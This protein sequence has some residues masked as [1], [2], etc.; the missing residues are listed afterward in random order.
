MQEPCLHFAAFHFAQVDSPPS[1]RQFR[2]AL[3]CAESLRPLPALPPTVDDAPLAIPAERSHSRHNATST[4]GVLGHFAL[5]FRQTFKVA[6]SLPRK[7]TM[8]LA[9]ST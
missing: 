4:P 9:S 1:A 5:T 2:Q 3:R 7:W 8:R 6:R